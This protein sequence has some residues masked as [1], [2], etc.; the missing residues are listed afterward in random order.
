MTPSARVPG[1][2]GFRVA[3]VDL[4][5]CPG[6]VRDRLFVAD[7]GIADLTAAL[8]AAGLDAPLMVLATC[9]RV[10]VHVLAGPE[11]DVPAALADALA[12]T[13]GLPPGDIGRRIH[14]LAG[15][16]AVRHLF[17][18]TAALESEVIGESQILGQVRAAH[19]AASGLGTVDEDLDRFLDAACAAARRVR[20]ETGIAR[21]AVSLAASALAI[22]R[23]IHGELAGCR[24]AV[25]GAGEL[26][27]LLAERFRDAGVRG[28]VVCDRSSSRAA[29]FARE[30]GAHVTDFGGWTDLLA[31]AEIVISA[32]G[33][34]R[35]V[36][37]AETVRA[38]LSRRRFRPVFVLDLAIPCDVE[39]S[40]DA[41][42]GVYVYDLDDLE[43]L[44]LE[45]QAGRR[46]LVSDAEAILEDELVRFV[47][48]FRA[49]DAV[50]LIRDVREAFETER[51][52][53]LRERPGLD[54]AEATRLLTNRLL[55]R[56]SRTLREIARGEGL[57]SRT[58]VLVRALLVPPAGGEGENGES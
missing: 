49:R 20:S 34:G 25:I 31:Q 18:I 47:G 17:R 46:A 36:I 38:A 12:T 14:G 33:D 48:E 56:P 39:P 57:N 16:D 45:G 10:E 52:Q 22:A 54:A 23:R 19:R 27:R 29:S 6:D 40:T 32:N 37:T 51:R 2:D 55:H 11:R 5:T 50:P 8:R 24:V 35:H 42:E 21:G 1:P 43:G 28:M 53:L 4:R 41:I 58:E 44:A 3:G 13:S 26:V 15:V 30:T 7:A 9:D